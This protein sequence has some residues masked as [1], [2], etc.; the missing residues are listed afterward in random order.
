MPLTFQY[1]YIILI[2]L[3]AGFSDGQFSAAMDAGIFA[4]SQQVLMIERFKYLL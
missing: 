2:L 4:Y 1:Y 3:R